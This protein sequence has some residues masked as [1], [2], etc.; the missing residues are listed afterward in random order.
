MGTKITLLFAFAAFSSC[1]FACALTPKNVVLHYPFRHKEVEVSAG[2][3]VL[4]TL[5][6]NPTTGFKW[7]LVKISDETVVKLLEQRFEAPK[8]KVEMNR[9]PVT[10][11]PGKELWTFKAL[12][13]GLSRIQMEYSRPWEGGEKGVKK[14][15]LQ[16]IVK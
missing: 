12:K 8:P 6:S 4:I 9:G 15:V 7:E 10:G 3:T 16:I 5:E 2:G 13:K 14:F 11:A 1:L